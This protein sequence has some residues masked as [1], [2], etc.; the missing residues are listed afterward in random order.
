MEYP[1]MAYAVITL[2]EVIETQLLPS[3]LSA[4]VAKVVALT[5]VC[6]AAKNQTSNIYTGLEQGF[7]IL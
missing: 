4:Q 2:E 6:E 7:L 3:S 1:R 5:R